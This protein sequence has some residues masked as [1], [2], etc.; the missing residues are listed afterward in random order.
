[1]IT[2]VL[3]GANLTL[4][5]VVAVAC[6]PAKGK[7]VEVT[8]SKESWKRVRRAERAVQEFIGRGEVVYGVTTGFGAFKDRIIPPQ[9]VQ[10]LQCNILMS[11]AV[12][13]GEPLDEAT[14]RA[15]RASARRRCDCC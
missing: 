11:H 6:A 14:T 2:V 12:G 8:L 7:T 3:D 13:V 4:E 10:Q 1:M 15:I 9:Q 5:D